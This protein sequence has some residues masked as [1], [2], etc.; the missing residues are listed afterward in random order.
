MN[1]LMVKEAADKWGISM[2][3]ITYHLVA[4]RILDT[5]KKA[6]VRLIPDNAEKPEHL[7]VPFCLISVL[8]SASF[9]PAPDK[10]F[11]SEPITTGCSC[12]RWVRICF[13]FLIISPK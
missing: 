11:K 6:G 12:W 4:G 3:A 10:F 9:M 8:L 2:W 13:V 1:Y 5:F 7:R